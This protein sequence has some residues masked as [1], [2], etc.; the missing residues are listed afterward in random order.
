MIGVISPY[1]DYF[2]FSKMMDDGCLMM[3]D[4]CL[5]MNKTYNPLPI[6]YNLI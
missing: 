4:G 6:T 2:H 5:V 3:G 1:A